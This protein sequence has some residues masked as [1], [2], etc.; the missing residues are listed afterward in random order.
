M[1]EC[2]FSKNLYFVVLEINTFYISNKYNTCK[3]F[4]YHFSDLVMYGI[5]EMAC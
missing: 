4:Y 1:S 2:I 5:N 3:V